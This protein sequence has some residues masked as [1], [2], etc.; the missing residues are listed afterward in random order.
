MTQLMHSLKNLS[1]LESLRIDDNP[2]CHEYPHFKET[3]IVKLPL[4]QLNGQ[5]VTESHKNH[6]QMI[7][8]KQMSMIDMI[9]ENSLI[10]T[11]L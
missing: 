9:H 4:L 11:A 8:D 3:L 10:L 1:C 5:T 6:A 2:I 7:F